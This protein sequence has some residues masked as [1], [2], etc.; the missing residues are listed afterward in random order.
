MVD[1][2]SLLGDSGLF[3]DAAIVLEIEEG[4][5]VAR[6]LPGRLA[7]WRDRRRQVLDRR[8]QKKERKRRRREAAMDRR[9]AKLQRE[10]EK[11]KSERQAQV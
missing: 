6:L 11:R 1:E 7:R 2:S 10:A 3:P 4:D 8:R 5:A 9:R